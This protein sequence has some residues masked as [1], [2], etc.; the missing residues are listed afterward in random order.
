M[1][2]HEIYDYV[3]LLQS[4]AMLVELDPFLLTPIRDP[5]DVAVIQ[6]ALAGGAEAICT[7]DRDFSTPPADDFLHSSGIQVLSD[8]ELAK[9]LFTR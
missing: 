4:L 2:D 5:Q 8:V 7:V 1:S 3:M 6:T 9:I